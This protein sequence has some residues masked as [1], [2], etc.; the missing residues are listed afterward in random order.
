MLIENKKT[1]I[2]I[3][4]KKKIKHLRSNERFGLK[5]NLDLLLKQQSLHKKTPPIG[6]DGEEFMFFYLQLKTLFY[7]LVLA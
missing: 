4:Y 3:N 6:M 5:I 2:V 7:F 1:K